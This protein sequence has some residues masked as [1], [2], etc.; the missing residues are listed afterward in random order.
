[1]SHIKLARRQAGISVWLVLFLSFAV[2]PAQAQ[3]YFFDNYGIEQG[4]SE[5]KVYS[6]LQD[7]KD[8]IW[9]GTANGLSRF[10]GVILLSAFIYYMYN[11][12]RQETKFSKMVQHTSKKEAAKYMVLFLAS[13]TLLLISAHYVVRYAEALSL[14]LNI[15]PLMIGLF[16]ISFGT[17]LPELMFESRAVLTGHSSM[18]IGDLVGSVITNS[19]LVLGVTAIIHPISVN[20]LIYVTNTMFMLFSAF[21]FFTFAESYNKITWTEGISL[22]FL[23]VLFIIVEAYIKYAV[24]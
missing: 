15:S 12:M 9:L 18:A 6:L 11:L 14:D 2:L 3:D 19:S 7:S 8:Y 23:Y 20:S 22:L 17:S 4:L 1:M 5:Q 10:D 16:I 24:V 13:I 21:I